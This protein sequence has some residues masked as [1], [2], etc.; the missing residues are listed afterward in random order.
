MRLCTVQRWDAGAKGSGRAR[1]VRAR[2]ATSLRSCA[3]SPGRGVSHALTRSTARRIKS[4]VGG[5]RSTCAS[6]RGAASPA[7]AGASSRRPASSAA[8]PA[9][10]AA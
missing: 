3:P 6:S 9:S 4:G 8:T 5:R 1:T 10:A 2:S 7:S